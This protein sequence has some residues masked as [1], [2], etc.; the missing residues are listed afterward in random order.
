MGGTVKGNKSCFPS[1]ATFWDGV[2]HAMWTTPGNVDLM[3][4][5]SSSVMT[6]GESLVQSFLTPAAPSEKKLDLQACVDEWRTQYGMIAA[7][8]RAQTCMVLYIEKSQFMPQGE[9]TKA[10]WRLELPPNGVIWLPCFREARDL[11]IDHVAY[12]VSSMIVHSGS[13]EAGH[14][15]RIAFQDNW[16]ARTDH[17]LHREPDQDVLLVWLVDANRYFTW[18]S[19]L[20][21]DEL[22]THA[23]RPTTGSFRLRTRSCHDCCA[24]HVRC[25]GS[26]S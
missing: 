12:Q 9:A 26:Q 16:E 1:P 11:A 17:A 22:V 13:H 4:L 3:R 18:P 6:K 25:A 14:Y 19:A 2:N 20:M 5:H 15:G 23:V 24:R 7:L 10:P 21:K 8:L